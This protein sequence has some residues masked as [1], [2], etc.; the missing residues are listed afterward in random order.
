MKSRIDGAW[1]GWNG[2]TVVKLVNGSVWRQ[3][4]YYYRYQY[5]Y[6]PDVI[7]EGNRMH[8]DGMPKAVRVRRIA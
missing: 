6:R 3:E 4:Q 2:D 5:R 1:T 8:V 7:V